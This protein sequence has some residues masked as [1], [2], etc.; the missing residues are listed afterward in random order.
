M[1]KFHR[2]SLITHINNNNGDNLRGSQLQ[3]VSV[4]TDADPG[5]PQVIG[6]AAPLCYEAELLSQMRKCSKGSYDSIGLL[7][8][9][10]MSEQPAEFTAWVPENAIYQSRS[11]SAKTHS[12]RMKEIH[13]NTTFQPLQL[14]T[15][16]LKKSK[17][18]PSL[19]FHEKREDQITVKSSRSKDGKIH[20]RIEFFSMTV[21][22]Q[23]QQPTPVANKKERRVRYLEPLSTADSEEKLSIATD[24][25]TRKGEH[26]H[27]GD[28][29]EYSAAENYHQ[30]QS[31]SGR[32]LSGQIKSGTQQVSEEDLRQLAIGKQL[33]SDEDNAATYTQY[34][35]RYKHGRNRGKRRRFYHIEKHDSTRSIPSKSIAHSNLCDLQIQPSVSSSALVQYQDNSSDLTVSSSGSAHHHSHRVGD[36]ERTLDDRHSTQEGVNEIVVNCPTVIN[37][38]LLASP[39]KSRSGTNESERVLSSVERHTVVT[40]PHLRKSGHRKGFHLNSQINPHSKAAT[41]QILLNS[42][43][44]T[45]RFLSSSRK[46]GRIIKLS[47]AITEKSRELEGP[48]TDYRVTLRGS[49]SASPDNHHQICDSS[50]C[51]LRSRQRRKVQLQ[52]NI[53]GN[54]RGSKKASTAEQN[55]S[56]VMLRAYKKAHQPVKVCLRGTKKKLIDL[57]RTNSSNNVSDSSTELPELYAE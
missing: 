48:N 38:S 24:K 49:S 8:Q 2:A 52:K 28:P 4:M 29:V 45:E 7:G 15:S 37:S 53:L 56:N 51:M 35:S 18:P 36:R 9:M 10:T 27:R 6:R 57:L 42:H 19:L 43:A 23:Q 50:R 47:H 30:K 54:L 44:V 5:R 33:A 39:H 16:H 12:S 32:L 3:S 31:Y 26:N 40:Y 11:A 13:S 41:N 21:P 14:H 55:S 34:V 25:S 22:E 20:T 1:S 17:Y 46:H